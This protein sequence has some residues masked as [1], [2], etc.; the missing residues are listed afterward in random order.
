VDLYKDSRA[1]AKLTVGF[2]RKKVYC[3]LP[4]MG[5]V[6]LRLNPSQKNSVQAK[7]DLLV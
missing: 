6:Q 5:K 4:E 1:L 3:C 7:M 2:T